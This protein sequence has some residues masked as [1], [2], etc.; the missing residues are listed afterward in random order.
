MSAAVLIDKKVRR[1]KQAGNRK[2]NIFLLR[3][4]NQKMAAAGFTSRETAVLY[5]LALAEKIE[6]PAEVL[7]SYKNLDTVIK[8]L[9]QKFLLTGKEKDADSQ[10]FLGKLLDY[11]KQITV[12]RLNMRK[13]L[14]SSNEI[15]AGQE[16]QVVLADMGIFT[17]RVVHHDLYFAV[18]SPVFFDLPPNFK[19]ENRKV[20]VFFRKKNDG[21]YSFNT[22]VAQEITD[23][24]T[25]DFALLM[26]HQENLFH[27]QKRQS[28]RALL[29][30]RAHFYSA[31]SGTKQNF[32]ESKSCTLYDIS[33]SGCSVIMEGKMNAARAVIIQIVL[34]GQLIG[35]NGECLSVQYNKAKNISMLHIRADAMPRE[36]K[37][38]ILAVM[39]GLVSNDG[40]MP[41]LADPPEDGNRNAKPLDRPNAASGAEESAT[42]GQTPKSAESPAATEFPVD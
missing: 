29:N 4:F 37:N 32:E 12:Q 35:I 14:F 5:E 13:R 22:V 31:S 10:E 23:P 2:K 1:G 30:K 28:L 42:D 3:Q 19:W 27:T 39:F 17:T 7:R 6:N 25:G 20:I 36:V 26:H 40:E 38:I 9:M 21:E 41:V 24:G 34:N 11:R 33:D 8:S 18:L 16:V 15:R